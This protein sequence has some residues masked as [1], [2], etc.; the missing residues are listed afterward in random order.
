M[1][2]REF[3]DEFA[4][5]VVPPRESTALPGR[6]TTA[7]TATGGSVDCRW[8]R[9]LTATE[10]QVGKGDCGGVDIGARWIKQVKYFLGHIDSALSLD[11]LSIDL[12]QLP[13]RCN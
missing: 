4:G 3:S 1:A 2:R 6:Q 8:F 13:A 11:G 9:S 12:T 5:E 10:K 7:Q